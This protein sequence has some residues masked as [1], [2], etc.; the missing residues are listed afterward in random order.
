VIIADGAVTTAKI[1]NLAVTNGK[2][3]DGAVT[4]A[5][6]GSSA[7]TGNKIADGAITQ[8][9]LAPGAGGTPA[10]GS[11]TYA[12]LA[13]NTPQQ[14]IA[15]INAS[16]PISYSAL[17][18]P[19]SP[20]YNISV[21]IGNTASTVARGN[22]T[23]PGN[24]QPPS[25]SLRFKKDITDYEVDG[26]KLLNL[27]TKI[28]KYKAT[29]R[30]Q[31]VGETNNRP[32]VLGLIAEEVLEAGIEEVVGY[33]KDGLPASLRYDLLTIYTID[34]LKRHENEIQ[35]LKEEIERLKGNND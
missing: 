22:H 20:G 25:S 21:S 26:T 33:D 3:R 18:G 17:A 15:R 9:K 1:D 23:H 19:G 13:I 8:A 11:I 28:F 27:Q 35:S 5:K 2:I 24:N 31:Q 14:V 32:W 30:D 29:H 6:I 16:A 10:D 7:V 4:N 34:L 12:K